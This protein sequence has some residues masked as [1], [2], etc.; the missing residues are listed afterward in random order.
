MKRLSVMAFLV[1]I[2]VAAALS[3]KTPDAS[4]GET[5]KTTVNWRDTAEAATLNVKDT[6]GD[7][8]GAGYKPARIDWVKHYSNVVG[9]V[10][11][12]FTKDTGTAA[13][14]TIDT[15]KDTC[16]FNIWTADETFAV[17][18]K[19][20]TSSKFL[21]IATITSDTGAVVTFNLSDSLLYSNIWFVFESWVGDSDATMATAGKGISYQAEVYLWGR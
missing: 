19:V 14:D 21:P 7:P 16:V 1:I 2:G 15:S 11:F 9:A 6:V 20:Y 18:R 10:T 13:A 5:F 12:E 3:L 8:T 17:K 4:A